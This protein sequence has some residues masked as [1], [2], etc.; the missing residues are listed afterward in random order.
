[1]W[2]DWFISHLHPDQNPK[3]YKSLK[4]PGW[5][6]AARAA[7]MQRR[8][9]WN[10]LPLHC[11]CASDLRSF[12]LLHL[13]VGFQFVPVAVLYSAVQRILTADQTINQPF[14]RS[15]ALWLCWDFIDFIN[16]L[17]GEAF[18]ICAKP[19]PCRRL[20]V[21]MS[22]SAIGHYVTH[23]GDPENVWHS[24]SNMGGK[25]SKGSAEASVCPVRPNSGYMRLSQT[26]EGVGDGG[27][28]PLMLLIYV[29]YMFYM[30]TMLLLL[31]FL[32]LILQKKS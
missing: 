29:L 17:L 26:G 8:S 31:F 32:L 5:R 10:C 21:F 24:W 27:E 22:V 25:H 4:A 19:F 1:M 7:R 11:V 13:L 9:V 20:Q 30:V 3:H 12:V 23:S 28:A 2:R 14:P 16:V 18:C 15:F 6:R